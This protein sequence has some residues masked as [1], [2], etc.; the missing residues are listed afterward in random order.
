MRA[1]LL[2]FLTLSR[3]ADVLVH[4]PTRSVGIDSAKHLNIKD[5][6]STHWNA[7][8]RSSIANLFLAICQGGWD[9]Q[10]CTGTLLHPLGADC[11]A[12]NGIHC[13]HPR[14]Q[15]ENSIAARCSVVFS[16]A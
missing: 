8:A 9:V 2:K 4:E 6:I 12:F 14:L 5:N 1:N 13:I 7:Q 3:Q 10:V 16:T 11:D 15:L